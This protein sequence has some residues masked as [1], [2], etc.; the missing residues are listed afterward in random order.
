VS[1]KIIEDFHKLYYDSE[2][3]RTNLTTWMGVVTWKCPFDLWVIQELLFKVQPDFLIETGTAFGGSALFFASIFELIGKGRVITIDD[4]SS[5]YISKADIKKRPVHSRILYITGSS[6]D[7]SIAKQVST[8]CKNKKVMVN[9]DAMHE[10]H[11]VYSEL[12][13]YGPLVSLGSYIIVEDT[14]VNGNPVAEDHGPGPNEAVNKWLAEHLNFQPDHNC[15]RLLM[16][17]NP[18]GYL[19][20]L[21]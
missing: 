16:T 19:Q 13:L 18:G 3:W 5:P 9:L 12:N 2:T 1:K 14:N 4:N 20:R 11:H 7:S 10:E 8:I 6:I 15:E 21:S 17:F